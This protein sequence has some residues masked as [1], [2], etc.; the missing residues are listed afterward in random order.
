VFKTYQTNYS[1]DIEEKKLVALIS[2][3]FIH[4]APQE[5]KALPIY[6]P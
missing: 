6:E 1:W 5:I 3:S 4:D 2:D